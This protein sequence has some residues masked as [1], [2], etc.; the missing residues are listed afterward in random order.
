M[1]GKI[2][3]LRRE[4]KQRRREADAE[5]ATEN[6]ARH[7]VSK[8]DRALDRAEKAKAAR[9]LDGKKRE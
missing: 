5:A 9:D 6:A 4:R 2:I 3:N 8:A 7:G 1:S